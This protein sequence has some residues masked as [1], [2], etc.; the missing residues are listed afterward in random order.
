MTRLIYVPA[1]GL[2]ALIGFFLAWGL[3]PRGGAIVCTDSGKMFISIGQIEGIDPHIINDQLFYLCDSAT[4][5][6]GYANPRF[7][8]IREAAKR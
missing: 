8:P 6:F 4:I 2:A 7:Y 5:G 3:I 1:I